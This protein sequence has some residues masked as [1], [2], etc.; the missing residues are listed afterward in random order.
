MISKL[1]SLGQSYLAPIAPYALIAKECYRQYGELL[2]D[3]EKAMNYE[4]KMRAM[5][6]KFIKHRA[7][8]EYV[9]NLDQFITTFNEFSSFLDELKADGGVRKVLQNNQKLLN[10]SVQITK[11]IQ[12]DP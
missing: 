7:D 10:E 12:D 3:V 5:A 9:C 8:Y 2:K 11:A 4:V 1:L 6:D